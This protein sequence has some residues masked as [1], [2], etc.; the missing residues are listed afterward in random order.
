MTSLDWK[1]IT[2][3]THQNA[4]YMGFCS[5]PK[6]RNNQDLLKEVPK[7]LT[8]SVVSEIIVRI[9]LIIC[10]INDIWKHVVVDKS[11][12]TNHYFNSSKFQLSVMLGAIFRPNNSNCN[13][14]TMGWS[15]PH[16]ALYQD[17][18]L[19]TVCQYVVFVTRWSPGIV[20]IICKYWSLNCFNNLIISLCAI[21]PDLIKVNPCC[22]KPFN[23]L[24]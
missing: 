21:I 24:W 7:H 23:Y 3:Q 20:V 1:Y 9:S 11:K 6:I 4:K 2:I 14:W 16:L 22:S 18:V 17:L 15:H 19:V 5:L 13:N 10:R 12:A 8:I